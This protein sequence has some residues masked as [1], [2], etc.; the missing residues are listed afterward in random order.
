MRSVLLGLLLGIIWNYAFPINK[1]LWTSSYVVFTAG[2][3]C[4]FLAL[5]YWLIDVNGYRWWTKPFVIFGMNAL[6]AFVLS[7]VGARLLGLISVGTGDTRMTL[8]NLIYERGFA[9][10]LAP[11][12]ASLIRKLSP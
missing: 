6:L 4:H 11:L 2:M 8:K 9:S 3:A 1:S 7:G 10:W 5:C 12:N